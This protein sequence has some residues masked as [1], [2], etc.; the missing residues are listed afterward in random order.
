MAMHGASCLARMIDALTVRKVS[1]PEVLTMEKYL[2]NNA[3]GMR[4]VR[5]DA[6]PTDSSPIDRPTGPVLERTVLGRGYLRPAGGRRTPEDYLWTQDIC[7]PLRLIVV[8]EVRPGR[9]CSPLSCFLP[10]E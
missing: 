6:K 1:G 2:R 7:G 10:Y 8:R 4:V 3:K 5:L 9:T